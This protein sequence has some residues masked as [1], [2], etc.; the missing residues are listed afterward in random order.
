MVV[1]L[2]WKNCNMLSLF[3]TQDLGYGGFLDS[4]ILLIQLNLSICNCLRSGE[5]QRAL[6]E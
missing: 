2:S 4:R 5:E 1:T 6:L 3:L